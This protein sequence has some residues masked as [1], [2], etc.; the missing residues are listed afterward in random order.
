MNAQ[1][2]SAAVTFHHRSFAVPLQIS[3]GTISEI[4]EARA[5]VTVAVEGRTATGRGAIYLSDL[6]AWPDPNLPH[7]FRDAEMRAFCTALALALPA[8]TGAPAHPLELGLRL[9]D[10]LLASSDGA[11]PPLARLVCASPF[12][13]A[14]HDAVG[15]ALRRSAFALYEEDAPIPSGD[16]LFPGTGAV[17]A[18]RQMLRRPPASRL[19]ATLVVGKGDP[20]ASL[21]PWA[22][23]RGYR[24][25][26]LKIGGI[27]P[28]EDAARV[29][30][31]FREARRLGVAH[32]RL[33]VDSNC[34]SPD[35][36]TVLHFLEALEALDPEAYAALVHIE[37]PTA[38]DIA[39]HPFDWRPVAARRPLLL[40][41]GLVGQEALE[42]AERQGWNG[43]A[44]KTCKG[45]SFALAV[46]AWAHRRGWALT[47][48]D[49]TNPGY[50]AIHGALLAAHLPGQ[51]EV[52]L[53]A[54]Q[55]TPAAN[56]E[57]LPR[58]ASL[59]TPGDGIHHL[60]DP[61]PPGLG[62]AL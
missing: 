25:F 36:V 42:T 4:T 12:D 30:V 19:E 10:G 57:W 41:E 17:A 54:W 39:A 51:R 11:L 58:L 49:L 20:L 38:R 48:A 50:A 52:E 37:Q 34:A 29:S 32:P 43:V 45:H 15:Y 62:S 44:L 53:N 47:V 27:D 8:R 21:A 1:V 14:I 24:F 5:E 55:F 6:W 28:G 56:D 13:A 18:I 33:S 22:T 23:E 3:S 61:I 46:A 9:H 40:D 60:P 26:K 31:L 7:G 2:L 59:L 16:S 35:A